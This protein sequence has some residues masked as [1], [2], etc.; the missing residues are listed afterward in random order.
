ML[1]S[2]G[3][4]GPG[5]AAWVGRRSPGARRR[6]APGS[7]SASGAARWRTTRRAA[8]LVG[9][10]GVHGRRLA[11]S[12]RSRSTSAVPTW[13]TGRACSPTRPRRRRGSWRPP[14]AGCR[15]G[16]SSAPTCPTWSR[17]PRGARRGRRRRAD[18]GEHAARAWPSTPS[19]A[20]P[21]W[22]PAG[23]G[24]RAP[25]C[26]RWR[27]GP[28]GSAGPPSPTL[29]IVGVGGVL[30]GPRRRRAA[31]GRRRRRPGRAPPPSATPGRPWKVLRQL[32]RWCDAHGTTVGEIRERVRRRAVRR[33]PDAA[34]TQAQVRD[35]D[36]RIADTKEDDMAD[37][38]G[39]RVAA[40]VAR[41]RAAV[42]GHRPLGRAAARLGADRR[43]HGAA[44]LLS[45]RAS[46]RSPARSA[47]SS[48]RSPSSSGTARRA[49][50]SSSGSSP[51][52][53]AAGLVVIADA[54]RGDIDSTA[55]RPTPTPGWATPARSPPTP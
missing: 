10:R 53:T 8:E 21:S 45:R 16:P 28:C 5:L 37:S 2:V 23:A 46:R 25:P 55:R 27:S 6:R 12:W 9:G 44:R 35:A 34:P 15:A 38:F 22:A 13:R 43:R 30:L 54:K 7:S 17:S 48:H 33:R 24:C 26:T 41:D 47:W 36:R 11:A 19:R 32:A 42:R 50:P 29:P 20:G 14:R 40:A 52:R 31:A 1:N 49:W 18:A 3:L 39:D 51:R 4:Q